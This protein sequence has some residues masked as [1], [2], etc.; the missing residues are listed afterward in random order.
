MYLIGLVLVLASLG[1]GG[2]AA[3]TLYRMYESGAITSPVWATH[4]WFLSTNYRNGLTPEAKQFL[5]VFGS[6][7]V[8]LLGRHLMTLG[9]TEEL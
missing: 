4:F 6:F 2:K 3:Y 5:L 8:F 9:D 7:L 1:V